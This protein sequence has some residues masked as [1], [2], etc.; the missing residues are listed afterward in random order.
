MKTPIIDIAKVIRSKNSGPFELTMDI[1]FKDRSVY[2]RIKAG[3][4]ITRQMIARAY[5]IPEKAVRNIIYFDPADAVKITMD[6]P[7]SS[8]AP[9]ETDV[10]GA[11]QHA[12][13]L[14]LEFDL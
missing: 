4:M 11:Q 1:I 5:R 7:L 2:D 9:G 3:D 10:Y 13:L 8:G 14:K 12:P 6:R